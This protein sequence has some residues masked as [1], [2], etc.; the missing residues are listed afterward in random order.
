[1]V[2]RLIL[3]QLLLGAVHG[4]KDVEVQQ[5]GVSGNYPDA[6]VFIETE[7]DM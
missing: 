5:F 1:M 3:L 4:L 7:G 6:S 2:F